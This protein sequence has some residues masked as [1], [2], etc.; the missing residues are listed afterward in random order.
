MKIFVVIREDGAY[1]DRFETLVQAFTSECE[2]KA[3]AEREEQRCCE[4]H[5]RKG[6]GYIRYENW[7]YAETELTDPTD[8]APTPAADPTAA[9]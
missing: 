9:R 8:S 6:G 2:A 5:A 3:M 7:Y 4:E 1:S